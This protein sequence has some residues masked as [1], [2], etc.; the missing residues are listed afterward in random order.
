MLDNTLNPS[1][2]DLLERLQEK[3]K[4]ELDHLP[5]GVMKHSTL[6]TKYL[7]EGGFSQDYFRTA[8]CYIFLKYIETTEEERLEFCHGKNCDSL[9][10]LLRIQHTE[11]GSY[12]E[13]LGNDE[14]ATTIIIVDLIFYYRICNEP[15]LEAF[16][17]RID[18]YKDYFLNLAKPTQFYDDMVESFEIA[19]LHYEIESKKLIVLINTKLY[20]MEEGI[21]CNHIIE[22]NL[23]N[24][25]TESLACGLLDEDFSVVASG[26]KDEIKISLLL[27]PAMP[28]KIYVDE[29]DYE[30]NKTINLK[31]KHFGP[32]LDSTLSNAS[33]IPSDYAL[34]TGIIRYVY[35]REFTEEVNEWTTPMD[36]E[37]QHFVASIILKDGEEIPKIGNIVSA[38]YKLCGVLA[39]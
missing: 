4:M 3:L 28:L 33:T 24:H 1:E 37:T 2:Q 8:L 17:Q 21:T 5:D 32:S 15:N 29:D 20:P 19:E 7:K 23:K 11:P 27:F 25:L 13:L 9:T 35:E 38:V 12:L 26:K 39:E 6:V 18:N 34:V 30:K 14:L 36:L 31:S 10:R 22:G 16:R